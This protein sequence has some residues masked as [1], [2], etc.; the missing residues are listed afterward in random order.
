MYTLEQFRANLEKYPSIKQFIK[1]GLIGLLNTFIDLI[2][3]VFFTRVLFWHYL[4]AAL[5]AFVIAATSSFILNSYWT[6]VIQD[7]L[8]ERYLNFFLV[9]LGG[10]M[11]TELFLYILVDKFFWFDLWAKILIVLVVVNWNFFLQKYWTF[12]K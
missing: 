1:F 12:K 8:K 7:K 10:L 3:Y 4:V 5:L 11:W 6:F 2:A 9:A